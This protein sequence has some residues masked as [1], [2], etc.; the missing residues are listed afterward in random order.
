MT[1]VCGGRWTAKL[2][3][4]TDGPLKF[5]KATD[6]PERGLG[7]VRLE[8]DPILHAEIGNSICVNGGSEPCAA[9]GYVRHLG[10]RFSVDRGLPVTASA[11]IA[12]PVG[13]FGWFL[14]LDQGAPKKLTIT[15]TEVDPSTPLLL[16]IA[17]PPGTAIRI[18]AYAGSCSFFERDYSCI[19]TFSQVSSVKK[20]RESKGNTYHLSPEGVLTFR[21]IQTAANFVGRPDWFLPSWDDPGRNGEGF[22]LDRF[23]RKNVRIP[24]QGYSTSLEVEA[25]CNSGGILG[26]ITELLNLDNDPYCD[27]SIQAHEVDK[28]CPNQYSQVSYDKCCRIDDV[29]ECIFANGAV[30]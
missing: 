2:F 27:G 20:V 12:G 13:G 3:D 10:P 1:P 28:V 30:A 29:N 4:D 25:S 11:D 26:F 24:V 5:I 14:Q 19:E 17:Y 6:G 8:W 23:E 22:A 16:S 18:T 9:V 15:R 21:I 7:H